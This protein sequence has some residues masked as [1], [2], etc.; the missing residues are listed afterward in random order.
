MTTTFVAMP[1]GYQSDWWPILGS[2]FMRRALVGGTIV[3]L[4]AGLLGY[5]IVVRQT[6]FAAHA[7][8]HMHIGLPGATGAVLLG[9]YEASPSAA[10]RPSDS[11]WP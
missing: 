6:A 7:S 10:F 11:R 8:A 3:A 4:A 1:I 2:A 5:F 9:P